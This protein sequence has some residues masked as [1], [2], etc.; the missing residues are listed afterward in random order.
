[1]I[2]VKS[3]GASGV[4][5]AFYGQGTGPV[6][7]GNVACV[8]TESRL[9]DCPSVGGIGIEYCSHRDDMGIVCLPG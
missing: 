7:L 5:N 6:L 8:G 4:F 9:F 1:M 3:S 2:S